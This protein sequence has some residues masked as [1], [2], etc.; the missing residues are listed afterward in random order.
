MYLQ[1]RQPRLRTVQFQT[2]RI[3]FGS[4]DPLINGASLARENTYKDERKVNPAIA[5]FFTSV[6]A[7]AALS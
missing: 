5:S 7:S 6:A 1:R 3:C 4:K 2:R